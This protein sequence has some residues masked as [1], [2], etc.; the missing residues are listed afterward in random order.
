MN[1]DTPTTRTEFVDLK[2]RK[3]FLETLRHR[4][5]TIVERVRRVRDA[6]KSKIGVVNKRLA[7]IDKQLEDIDKRLVKVEALMDSVLE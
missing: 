1:T 4:R 5:T 3:A 7:R 2:D 6:T